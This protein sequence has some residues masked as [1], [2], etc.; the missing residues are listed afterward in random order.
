MRA[1]A[2]LLVMLP[3]LLGGACRAAQPQWPVLDT[4][5]VPYLK[6]NG[7]SSYADFLLMN[8][9][10]AIA[11]ASNG[12]YGWYGGAGSIADARSK[13]LKLCTDKGGVGCAI[14][15]EDLQ[16]V[17]QGRPAQALPP[18]PGPLIEAR[19]YAFV[20]DPRYIWHGPQTALGVYV[21]AHGTGAAQDSRGIQP[22]PHVRAFNDAGFDIVRFDRAPTTDYPD[23]AAEWLHAGLA[24]LRARGW[25]TIVA[26]GQSRGAWNSLQALDTPGLA[27]AVIAISPARFSSQITQEADLSRILRRAASSP[28]ARVAVAQFTGDIYVRDMPG[29]IDMLRDLLP[30]R[31]AATLVI[32]Q[33]EGITGHGGGNTADFARRFGRCLLRFVTDTVPPKECTPAG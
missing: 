22:Q 9:S 21:W 33:P 6:A 4:E 24:A 8:L 27:D 32:D 25:R 11:V 12:T 5:A 23:E 18:V 15:A 19:D 17:W 31:V 1:T 7:R 26:A 13:A 10:R 3:W 30:S 16:V 14:Y 20:P 29:R 28:H 2:A